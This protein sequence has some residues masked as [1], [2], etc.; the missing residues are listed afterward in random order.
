MSEQE[1]TPI[2]RLRAVRPDASPETPAS[3][4]PGSP[5]VG[6][7][8]ALLREVDG[9]RLT[10]ETGLS[11]AASA[12][13]AGSPGLA[14]DILE[15]DRSSLAAFQDRA[16]GHLAD[17]SATPVVSTARR[18]R[19]RVPAAPFV[20]AAAIVGF[21]VGV[22]PTTGSNGADEVRVSTVAANSS[23]DQLKAFAAVGN[24]SQVRMTAATLHQQLLAV[25]AQA[26]S[27]PAAAERAL[28]MLSIER[29]AIEA[30]GDSV[31]LRDVLVRSAA[32]A[33]RI[34]NSL[35]ST[36]RSAIPAAPALEVPRTASPSPK[37]ATASPKPATASPT[38]S[39]SASPKPSP[40]ASPKPSGSSEPGVLPTGNPA[41]GD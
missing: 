30:S 12:V 11:L 34:R 1:G 39:P 31:A 24:T 5:R 35:P 20:A 27:D 16:L 36:I 29:N 13:D 10:L 9:L 23:L 33:K 28:L 41:G 21:L 7:L 14:L 15:D 37:A 18:S 4:L 3:I 26:G 40:S 6:A 22:V 17:L 25:V 38:P 32:L 2:R 8:D 19:F